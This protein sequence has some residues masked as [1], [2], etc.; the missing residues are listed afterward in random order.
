MLGCTTEDEGQ[1]EIHWSQTI[2]EA[3]LFYLRATPDTC[4][5]CIEV[6]EIA[7]LGVGDGPGFLVETGYEFGIVVDHS[8]RYWVPQP[9]GAI[10][11]YDATGAY[12]RSV[13]RAGQGPFDFQRPWLSHVDPGGNVHVLDPANRRETLIDPDFELVEM[14]SLQ[15]RFTRSASL[16]KGR[17]VIEA[18]LTTPAEIGFLLH[19]IGGGAVLRSFGVPL[20]LEG[21][22]AKPITAFEQQRI[23][24]IGPDGVIYSTKDHAYSIEAWDQ[25]GNRLAGFEGPTL[26]ETLPRAE[27]VS[28]DNPYV[29]RIRA[30]RVD[31]QRR[32]WVAIHELRPDWK[33]LVEEVISAAGDVYVIPKDRT[34]W[35]VYRTRLD[36][37]D[38]DAM[39][40]IASRR[41]DGLLTTFLPGGRAAAVQYGADM[42]VQIAIWRLAAPSN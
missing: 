13:G 26:N 8:D 22:N 38:L 30:T 29:H 12:L 2:D 6:E 31:E 11:V 19:I 1:A 3:G 10:Q 41:V 4:D 17:Y 7:R 14:R 25:D 34:N 23:L 42:N 40:I 20:P 32:L 39:T 24:T 18:M 27:P 21:E 37:V 28:W 9:A 15:D 33:D 5:E 35:A 16:G 36:L